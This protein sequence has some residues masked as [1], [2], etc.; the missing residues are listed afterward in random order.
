MRDIFLFFTK[1]EVMSKNKVSTSFLYFSKI[2]DNISWSDI[3]TKLGIRLAKQ[4][5]SHSPHTGDYIILCPFHQEK[6]PSLHL[7]SN[8][9]RFRCYGC[10]SHG[11]IFD[12]VCKYASGDKI[13]THR[14]FKK[15]F[16]IPYPWE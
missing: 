6:K 11:D 2:R 9:G 1:E 8:T 14:W 3:L 4:R 16:K 10:G 13:R 5:K 7:F 12:F 15:N